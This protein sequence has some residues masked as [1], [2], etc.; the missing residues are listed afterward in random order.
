MNV[1]V[2]AATGADVGELA[3]VY[4]AS[5]RAHVPFAP[6]V[7]SDSDVHAWVAGP[8]LASGGLHAVLLDRRI[9]GMLAVSRDGA[10]G[11]IDQLYVAP[12]RTRLG[13]GGAALRH[14]LHVLPRPVRLRTFGANTP[15]R[16]FYERHGFRAVGL[17]DGSGNEEQVPDVVYELSG[18]E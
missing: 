14:A 1:E 10:V 12:G 6:L 16:R 13:I 5:R 11:W 3:E 9:V 17:S 4:L 2:R 7:H 18:D 15:A 8:L